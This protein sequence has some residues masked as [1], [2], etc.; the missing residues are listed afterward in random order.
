[1]DN[2]INVTA[3]SVSEGATGPVVGNEFKRVY[4]SFYAWNWYNYDFAPGEWLRL[5]Y[6]VATGCTQDLVD[7]GLC[8][9]ADASGASPVGTDVDAGSYSGSVTF[10]LYTN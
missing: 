3:Q 4:S 10:T 9:V 5:Y 2:H 8:D 7:Q 1:M 6:G